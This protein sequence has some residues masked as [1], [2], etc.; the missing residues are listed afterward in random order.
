MQDATNSS[1]D[2][3]VQS[4]PVSSRPPFGFKTSRRRQTADEFAPALM[5]VFATLG[6]LAVL[7]VLLTSGVA[8]ID[9]FEAGKLERLAFSTVT[10]TIVVVFAAFFCGGWVHGTL[11][12]GGQLDTHQGKRRAR[13]WCRDF[14][15]DA[16]G[17][18]HG[19]F[20]EIGGRIK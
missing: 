1:H 12:G 5:G 16:S 11:R 10:I 4:R 18:A 20:D 14:E 9:I 13:P 15:Y 3:R 6:V 19:H 2:Y 8:G 17:A 7:G